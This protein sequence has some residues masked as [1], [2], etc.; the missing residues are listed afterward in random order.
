MERPGFA[1][2]FRSSP[3]TK[4]WEPLYSREREGVID[5]GFDVTEAHCNS[6]GFLH[7]GVIATLADNAMG[8]TYVRAASG[9]VVWS[10]SEVGAVTVNLTIDYVSTAH[11]GQWVEINPR[12]IRAGAQL[13]FV[14]AIITADGR[15]AGRANA[16][17]RLARTSSA[18]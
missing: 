11:R 5:I 1:L 17:F 14:D 15:L 9:G 3:V 2:H 7:G 16:V 6:R 12:I 8:L 10:T 4:P 18:S 13:G